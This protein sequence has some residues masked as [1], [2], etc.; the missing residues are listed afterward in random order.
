M[1]VTEQIEAA[2]T[3]LTGALG[4]VSHKS[5]DRS[6]AIADIIRVARLA[7]LEEAARIAEKSKVPE[8]D[9]M[10]MTAHMKWRTG[11]EIAAEIRNHANLLQRLRVVPAAEEAENQ[12]EGG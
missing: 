7:A 1:T 3:L 9:T 8:W 4:Q 12:P 5:S 6:A 2:I 11:N 10:Q